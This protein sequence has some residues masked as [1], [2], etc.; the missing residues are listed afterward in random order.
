MHL[1][2][3][4]KKCKEITQVLITSIVLEYVKVSEWFFTI[5]C[6]Y[7][8]CIM[9]HICIMYLQDYCVTVVTKKSVDPITRL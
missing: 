2:K 3:E 1:K 6:F 5:V 9:L 7:D 4:Y 8:I